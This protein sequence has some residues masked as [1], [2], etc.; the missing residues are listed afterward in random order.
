[1]AKLG[2]LLVVGYLAF[3]PRMPSFMPS[4]THDISVTHELLGTA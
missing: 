4:E 2:H 3:R 1:M